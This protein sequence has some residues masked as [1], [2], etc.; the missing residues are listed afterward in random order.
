MTERLYYEHSYLTEFDAVVTDCVAQDGTCRVRL[1]RSAFYPTSGGQP[2]DTGVL[3]GASVTNVEVIDGD[4][5]HTLSAPLRVGETVHGV[6][7]WARRF[8]HMQQ[9]AADH[10]IAGA[11]HHLMRGVTIGLHISAD[12]STIDVA[13]PDG[14][15]HLT[16]EEIETIE[17]YVNERV[18]RDVPVRCWFPDKEE[19]KT[20]PLRKEPTVSEHVRVV[21]IGDDEMVACGGTHP[22][23][24]GQ[25]GLVKILNTVPARGLMRLSFVAGMRAFRDYRLCHAAAH[26]AAALC[27]TAVDQLPA[28]LQTLQERLQAAEATVAKL[29][30]E[31]FDQTAHMWLAETVVSP[32][33][34]MKTVSA[35]ANALKELASRLIAA[36]GVIALLRAEGDDSTPIVFARSQDLPVDMN[37]ILREAAKRFGGRG[38]GKPDFVQG[39]ATAQTLQEAEDLVREALYGNAL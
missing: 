28:A 14:R 36:Q 24:A 30:R 18:Q 15:T 11:L 9:H 6:I 2:F 10:M 19:L 26:Q 35:D 37:R 38:G 8:D 27:S 31:G 22:A 7:D 17:L 20:L 23:S 5:W 39:V 12:I 33:V 34:I 13:M 21:A 3:G 16:P 29:R 25:L 1:N 32:R 4:V